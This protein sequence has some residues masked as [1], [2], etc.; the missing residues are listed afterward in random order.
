MIYE[1]SKDN[2]KISIQ[3]ILSLADT[4]DYELYDNILICKK[5]IDYKRLACTNNVYELIFIDNKIPEINWEKYYEENF[6][7]RSNKASKEKELAGIIWKSLKTP[8][9]KLRNSKSEFNF[10]FIKDKIICGKKV[11]ERTE[12]FHIRRPDLRPGFFPVSLKPK[13]ARALINLSGVKKGIIWDP[14]CGTGGILLEA[15]MIGIKVIGT[16]IDP[17]M[18]RAAKENFKHYNLKAT[19]NVADA[20]TEIIKCKAVVCDPPYGRRASTKKTEVEELYNEFLEHAYNFIDKVVI[21]MPNT[22]KIKTKYK[23]KFSTEQFVHGSLTR[24]IMIL[25]KTNTK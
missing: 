4:E 14:F 9:V 19:F 7:V 15:A 17:I 20:R 10:F 23:I 18:I 16:D 21:M 1:L 13:L 12:P 25:E 8:K 5:I 2:L 11:F 3:E 22:I 6:C 24:R